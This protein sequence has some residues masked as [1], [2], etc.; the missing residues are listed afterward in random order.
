M[1]L[2][3]TTAGINKAEDAGGWTPPN[4]VRRCVAAVFPT[5]VVSYFRFRGW[6]CQETLYDCG[7]VTFDL[8][9]CGLSW[10]W[11]VDNHSVGADP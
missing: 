5:T 4:Q 3:R 6:I 9:Q 2:V 11:C 7:S 8:R 1:N 10:V